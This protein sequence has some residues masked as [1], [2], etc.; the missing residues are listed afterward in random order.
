MRY[1]SAMKAARKKRGF[2]QRMLERKSGISVST[3][4]HY[5]TGKSMPGLYN[6]IEITDALG[7]SIDEY[8]GRRNPWQTSE[9]NALN[10]PTG[11]DVQVGTTILPANVATTFSA[12]ENAELKLTVSASLLKKLL[13]PTNGRTE[14]L[15]IDLEVDLDA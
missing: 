1:A 3:L 5:E 6:L 12:P 7:I 9:S 11:K 8:I 14:R 10:A 15:C 2:T 13:D 4:N